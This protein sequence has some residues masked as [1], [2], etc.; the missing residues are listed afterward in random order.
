MNFKHSMCKFLDT[1]QFLYL[2]ECSAIPL[3]DHGVIDEL[4][5]LKKGALTMEY[6]IFPRFLAYCIV[7]KIGE[8]YRGSSLKLNA[9]LTKL[10]GTFFLC[11]L[12]KVVKN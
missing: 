1:H 4:K 11:R 7:K 9:K 2:A 6:Y 10:T 12:N 3:Q 5:Q 8:L